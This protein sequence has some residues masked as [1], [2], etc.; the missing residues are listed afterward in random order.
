MGG[1][2]EFAVGLE[3]LLSIPESHHKDQTETD[4]RRVGQGRC[5]KA[6]Q[7]KTGE[8]QG[9]EAAEDSYRN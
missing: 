9:S 5:F 6:L 7:H 8:V 1:T 3:E 4:H 2:E